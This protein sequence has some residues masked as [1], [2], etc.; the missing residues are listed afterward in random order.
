VICNEEDAEDADLLTYF[1]PTV[2][3]DVVANCQ[4][5]LLLS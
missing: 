1:T 2:A 5:I 4:G 3:R